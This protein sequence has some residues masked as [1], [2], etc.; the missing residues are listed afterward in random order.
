PNP[1]DLD[2]LV[3]T[4]R[5]VNPA[6]FNGVPTLYVALLNHPAV[7]SGKGD[8][9]SIKVCFS[10]AAPLMADTKRLF[11]ALT[12]SRI[13]EGYSL[14]EAMMALAVNPVNGVNKIGS[15]GMPLPDV[16]VRIFDADA[17]VNRLAPTEI[18]EIC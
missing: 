18:G 4:I 11:E 5:R 6:L 16:E 1:R 8:F 12:R 10:G 9:R 17:G 7:R 3:A 15:V 13:V 14:T 2:D